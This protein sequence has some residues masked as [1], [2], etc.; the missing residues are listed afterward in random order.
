ATNLYRYAGN[1]PV[2]YGDPSGESAV[3][4]LAGGYWYYIGNPGYQ[5]LTGTSLGPHGWCAEG[6]QILAGGYWRG[7]YHDVPNTSYWRQ[8]TPLGSATLPDTVIA[9]G[10]V[11]GH[12][13]G[14]LMSPAE[15]R[16]QYPEQ[17]LYH[18]AIFV[19]YIN[20]EA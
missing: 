11:N 13:A 10:W 12:Y 14:A 8:G 19:A 16:Q 20:G 3:Y 18:T 17:P 2:T 6:A 9:R 7:G 15:Y 4:K 5:N 1:N